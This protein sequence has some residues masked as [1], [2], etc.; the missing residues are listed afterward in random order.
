MFLML[1]TLPLFFLALMLMQLT[2][3]ALSIAFLLHSDTSQLSF[4]TEAALLGKTNDHF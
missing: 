3:S 4:R 1:L 2:L